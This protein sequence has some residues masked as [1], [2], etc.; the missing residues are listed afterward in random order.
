[1]VAEVGVVLLPLLEPVTSTAVADAIPD[2]SLT[3]PWR[4]AAEVGVQPRFTVIVVPAPLTFKAY[5]ISVLRLPDT[6]DCTALAQVAPVW[7]I[8]V[9]VWPVDPPP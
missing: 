5:Q 7:E 9:M 4:P 1:M 2:H 6:L 3:A 8:L